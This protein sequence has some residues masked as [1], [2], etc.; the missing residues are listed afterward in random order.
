MSALDNLDAN[1]RAVLRIVVDAQSVCRD[2]RNGNGTM[3]GAVEF[4]DEMLPR[5]IWAT[6]ILQNAADAQDRGEVRDDR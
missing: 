2:V 6:S 5:L 1:L 3:E 4:A